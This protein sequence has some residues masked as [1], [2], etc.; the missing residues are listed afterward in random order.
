MNISKYLNHLYMGVER[1]PG[2][3]PNAL[4]AALTILVSTSF[5]GG[6]N[7]EGD[8]EISSGITIF[9]SATTNGLR[10]RAVQGNN[11]TTAAG[12]LFPSQ[13]IAQ[14]F[15]SATGFPV[16]GTQVVFSET[17]STNSII[18]PQN[19][20]SDIFGNKVN[21]TDSAGQVAAKVQ[22]PRISN[23]LITIVAKIYKGSDNGLVEF[24]L[25][26]KNTVPAKIALTTSHG[27]I[28]TAGT[29]FDFTVSLNDEFGN[30]V[31]TYNGPL[32]LT[33]S[34][35]THDSWAW[36]GTDLTGTTLASGEHA[37]SLPQGTSL[38]NFTNGI[39][40]TN[41]LINSPDPSNPNFLQG[42]GP[43]GCIA[44][45]S[46]QPSLI[47]VRGNGI[48]STYAPI[49]NLPITVIGGVAAKTVFADKPG[50]PSGADAKLGSTNSDTEK[51]YMIDNAVAY[52][53]PSTIVKSA[54]ASQGTIYAALADKYGNF[55]K[56][57]DASLQWSP[58]AYTTG[59]GTNIASTALIT[60]PT[61]AN[62]T[63]SVNTITI[64]PT[65]TGTS[66]I[67]ATTSAGSG[68][69][70]YIVDPGAM[71]KV[72]V[73]TQ[74]AQIE[75]A[76]KPFNLNM[77][78]VDKKGNILVAHH[79]GSAAFLGTLS[80]TASILDG[81]S[82]PQISMGCNRLSIKGDNTFNAP[83][84][85][86]P[87]NLSPSPSN[88]A[89]AL[90]STSGC[91]ARTY[92]P[93]FSNG[94]SDTT[95][96]A[97]LNYASS[98]HSISPKIS[99]TLN[100][101]PAAYSGA[102][103]NTAAYNTGT[104]PIITVNKGTPSRLE[105]HTTGVDDGSFIL[106][107]YSVE[108]GANYWTDLVG[109]AIP[110]VG[111]TPAQASRVFYSILTDSAGNYLSNPADTT[112]TFGS[113][114]EFVLSTPPVGASATYTPKGVGYRTLVLRSVSA[115][116][117]LGVLSSYNALTNY[118]DHF[119]IYITDGGTS[120]PNSSSTAT[121]PIDV[122]QPLTLH[123]EAKDDQNNTARLTES[124]YL[125]AYTSGTI[126]ASPKGTSPILPLSG[127]VA[128]TDGQ[129]L[130]PIRIPN[131]LN[132]A[133]KIGMALTDIAGAAHCTTPAGVHTA[134]Y[135]S[136]S[137]VPIN[138]LTPVLK[139]GAI[140]AIFIK[141]QAN[142]AGNSLNGTTPLTALTTDSLPTYSIGAKDSEQNVIPTTSVGSGTWTSST[143]ATGPVAAIIT[144]VGTGSN[145]TL[146]P[147]HPGTGILTV[148]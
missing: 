3:N 38:C 83:F 24:T 25:N 146:S 122:T 90:G 103:Y 74:H 105:L 5:M 67:S 52:S 69:L 136:N 72:L 93:I 19:F 99:I 132:T 108:N 126:T 39:C 28:E 145:V 86:S 109:A 20:T 142:G 56:D 49:F 17:T 35:I 54:D 12:S 48:A 23:Q 88:A 68:F 89:V 114:Q 37:Y 63:V 40:N 102:P 148:S 117:G 113:A 96:T 112:W 55:V 16:A 4:L 31:D 34:N 124:V 44:T 53:N 33:W 50:G 42:C 115:N 22:A 8:T 137:G 32:Y 130:V 36:D 45:D 7:R 14:V 85:S 84:S 111:S 147:T 41:T 118:P 27:Q 143:L 9:D 128:F 6:C 46:S 29:P 70:T 97:S 73:S 120:S 101:L 141:D 110:K 64:T 57:S 135:C 75:T 95:L 119:E 79:D 77:S 1:R 65:A 11:Q 129:A 26:T 134:S 104:T 127:P 60:Y 43:L 92:T 61:A 76:G 80:A 131:L 116:G 87:I 121:Q 2:L 106:D 144:A 98:N 94:I 62:T 51:S 58:I 71:F 91:G 100:T 81:S 10:I 125:T 140:S 18:I 107:Q 133:I 21:V 47:S 138:F 15:D 66:T 78:V 139:A 123:I 13:L 59:S 30:L 82:D